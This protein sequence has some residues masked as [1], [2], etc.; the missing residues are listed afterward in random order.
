MKF[1]KKHKNLILTTV[2]LVLLFVMLYNLDFNAILEHIKLVG[3]KVI[4]ILILPFI[5][6]LC[7]AVAWKY[8][9]HNNGKGVHFTNLIKTEIVSNAVSQV[10]LTAGGETYK[11]FYLKSEVEKHEIFTSI[12]LT[13]TIHFIAS[14]SFMILGLLILF[15]LPAIPDYILV[16]SVITIIIISAILILLIGAQ[17]LGIFE[18]IY[19]KV[20][21][22]KVFEGK[23]DHLHDKILEMDSQLIHFYQNKRKEFFIV[24]VCFLILRSIAVIETI[25]IMM[26]L[27]LSGDLLILGFFLHSVTL[28]AQYIFFFLN[29]V[30]IEFSFFAVASIVNIS[31]VA[32]VS[33]ALVRK[34]RVIFWV[35]IGFLFIFFKKYIHPE[36]KIDADKSTEKY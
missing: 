25:L 1:L 34:I 5:A 36:K 2:G 11:A 32:L 9:L 14:I 33:V 10:S 13:N 18:K 17:K 35:I 26:F 4:I 28:L 29:L 15:F 12:L 19:H 31:Q 7:K 30:N 8:S 16:L 3:W 22:L 27:Q 6:T 24:L 20:K 23:I 21:K